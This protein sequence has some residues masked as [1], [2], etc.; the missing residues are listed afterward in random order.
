MPAQAI[1]D[2]LSLLDEE[3]RERDVYID[4]NI[5]GRIFHFH[6]GDNPGIIG[7]VRYSEKKARNYENEQGLTHIW[8]RYNREKERIQS[9][10]KRN[11][12]NVTLD[13]WE[14]DEFD[15]DE[16][17][18]IF[19]TEQMIDQDTYSKGDQKIFILDDG[20]Y[21]GPLSKYVDDW[22]AIF[23]YATGT[24]SPTPSTT[25]NNEA[26]TQSRRE[27]SG[28]ISPPEQ[29]A[30]TV[31]ENEQTQVEVS[32]E[33]KQAAYDRFD[34]RCGLS[35]I[36]QQELLTV[37]HVLDRA[38]RPDIAQDLKNVLILDWTHHAAF[39]AG[40][41]TFDELGRIWVKPSFES[42]SPSLQSSLVDRHGEKVEAL[43]KVD[44]EY[45]EEHNEE[46]DWWPP[47]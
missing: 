18:F 40:L 23:E 17:H 27:T 12:V 25:S 9:G 26:G 15:P 31:R 39:D 43:T 6:L 46:L 47:R 21:Q 34:H 16:H 14:K 37:S 45:I 41:W 36:E 28:G 30:G 8:H 4:T 20:A 22:D 38:S 44:A 5:N 29:I 32:E 1:K 11:V 3:A 10:S 19:L 33:F 42:Q 2:W 24:S 7:K 35:G 13:V